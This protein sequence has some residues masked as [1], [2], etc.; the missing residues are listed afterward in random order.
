MTRADLIDLAA[1]RIDPCAWS[2]RTPLYL[3]DLRRRDD[4]R[5]RALE[6][7]M[8]FELARLDSL[9]TLAAYDAERA[10]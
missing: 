5:R 8:V 7:F 6:V 10:A 9:D 1:Q 2:C 3:I 4:A